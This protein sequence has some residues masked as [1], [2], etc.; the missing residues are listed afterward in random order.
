MVQVDIRREL[1]LALVEVPH[2]AE[3]DTEHERERASSHAA[4]TD[5][6]MQK[7]ASTC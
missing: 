6:D 5:T 2:L 4:P 3:N 1:S 7:Q